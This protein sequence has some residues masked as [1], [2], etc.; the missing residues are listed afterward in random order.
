MIRFTPQKHELFCCEVHPTP[1][2]WNA[3][4]TNTDFQGFHR[5]ERMLYRDGLS[6]AS[7][8]DIYTGTPMLEW[9]MGLKASYEK[10]GDE[11]AAVRPSPPHGGAVLGSILHCWLSNYRN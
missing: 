11:L 6:D 5:I 3:G 10:L 9:A 1:R 8:E 4:E 2:H 7:D